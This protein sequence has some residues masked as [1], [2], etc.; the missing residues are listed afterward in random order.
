SVSFFNDPYESTGQNS[1]AILNNRDYRRVQGGDNWKVEYSRNW[2]DLSFNAYW[3]RHEGEVS[4]IAANT[5]V[6]D[7]VIYPTS[8]NSTLAQ[9]SLGG[10]GSNIETSRN[11]DE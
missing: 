2:G 6:S 3:F 11:R 4:N 5:T 9:R 7:T 1:A 8:A 10:L